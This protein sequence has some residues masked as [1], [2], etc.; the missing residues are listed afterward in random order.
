MRLET[1]W[2]DATTEETRQ[3]FVESTGN[4]AFPLFL[5][6]RARDTGGANG[7][8]LSVTYGP[9]RQ[10]DNIFNPL[11]ITHNNQVLSFEVPKVHK[12]ESVTLRVC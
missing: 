8:Q 12:E 3:Q 11:L 4:Q 6:A 7:P 9:F 10:V 5:L 2:N 1:A